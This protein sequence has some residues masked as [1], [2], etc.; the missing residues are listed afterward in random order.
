MPT[1]KIRPERDWKAALLATM[2]ESEIKVDPS[3]LSKGGDE[4]YQQLAP[5][6]NM[7]GDMILELVVKYDVSGALGGREYLEET[8]DS[9]QVYAILVK[10]LKVAFPFVNDLRGAAGEILSLL[11]LARSTPSSFT[12]GHSDTGVSD[13]RSLKAASTPVS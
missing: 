2:A 12:N 11:R 9:A 3:L 4:V 8:A 10:C 13:L 1:L 7:A 5:L 6:A